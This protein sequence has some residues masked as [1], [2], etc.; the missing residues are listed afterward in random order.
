MST[1]TLYTIYQFTYTAGVSKRLY[2]FR[3]IADSH[4]EAVAHWADERKLM[5]KV[6]GGP[7]LLRTVHQEEVA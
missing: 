7:I 6:L 4:E 2:S 1:T 5:R 3:T